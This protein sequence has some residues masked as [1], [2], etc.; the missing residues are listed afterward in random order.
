MIN[1]I[2]KVIPQL[3][4]FVIN[5]I[6]HIFLI[7][8][9]IFN[10]VE[11]PKLTLF[12][13]ILLIFQ[14]FVILILLIKNIISKN[15]GRSIFYLMTTLVLVLE[16]YLT[17]I[18]VGAFSLGMGTSVGD[19]GLKD[20]KASKSCSKLNK[21]SI[22]IKIENISKNKFASDFEKEFVEKIK[23]DNQD[24]PKKITKMNCGCRISD[25]TIIVFRIWGEN[26]DTYELEMEK[27][28]KK[29]KYKSL[30]PATFFE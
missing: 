11:N 4:V 17:F 1:K 7:L 10:N 25:S 20:F 21:D 26:Q 14:F 23:L 15:I 6:V 29:W 22:K 5:S 24:L 18:F 19:D 2:D 28:N 8:H 3:I 13:Y 30:G 27:Q 12:F 16:L 9:R